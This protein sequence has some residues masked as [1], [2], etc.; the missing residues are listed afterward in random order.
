MS[1]STLSLTTL[2]EQETRLQWPQFDQQSAWQLGCKLKEIAEQREA[3]VALEVYAFGQILFS[4]A[5]P[6][7]FITNQQWIERKRHTVLEY[8]HSSYYMGCYNRQKGRVFEQLAH[9][10]AHYYCAHG[11]AFPLRIRNSGL[12]GAVSASGLPETEDHALLVDA[13]TA[14]LEG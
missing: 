12:I 9:V 6:G 5:M 10:D 4:Y 11:G 7:S 14:L 1:E 2:L 8:G 13:L 3:S